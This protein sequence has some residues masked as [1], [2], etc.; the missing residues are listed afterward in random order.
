MFNATNFVALAMHGQGEGRAITPCTSGTTSAV[1][2]VFWLHGQVVVNDMTDA[3]NV[4]ATCGYVGGDQYT[5][6]PILNFRNRA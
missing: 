6:S 5:Y 4:D 2:I 3:L 1:N